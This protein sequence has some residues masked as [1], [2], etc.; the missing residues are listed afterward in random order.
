[1]DFIPIQ[2]L[3][4]RWG[5]FVTGPFSQRD[6]LLVHLEVVINFIVD[7]CSGVLDPHLA[8]EKEHF[9]L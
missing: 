5:C 1:M 6:V 7:T 3:I 2:K 4:K 8:V 9:G